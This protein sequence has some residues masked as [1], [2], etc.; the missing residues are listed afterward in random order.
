M[1]LDLVYDRQ[2]FFLALAD[3]CTIEG[4]VRLAGTNNNLTTEG[5]VEICLDEVWGTVCDDGWDTLAAKVVCRQLNLTM[6]CELE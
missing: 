4:E 6:D 3:K 5:R 1:T 2:R